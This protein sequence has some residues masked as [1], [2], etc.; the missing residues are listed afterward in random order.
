MLRRGCTAT[1]LC[2]PGHCDQSTLNGFYGAM[3]TL[4]SQSPY[5]FNMG[6]YFLRVEQIT[7][8]GRCLTEAPNPV[9]RARYLCSQCQRATYLHSSFRSL[10]AN[11]KVCSSSSSA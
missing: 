1:S 9:S 3:Q 10:L 8:G 5:L 11:V 7:I 4:A 6:N 2:I